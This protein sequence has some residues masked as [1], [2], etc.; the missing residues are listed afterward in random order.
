MKKQFTFL[1]LS[2]SLFFTS[3][4]SDDSGSTAGI[5]QSKI[6]GWWYRNANTSTISYNAYY[7]GEDGEYIQ[8]QSNLGM[9]QGVGTW[10]WTGADEVTITPAANGGIAGGV[11]VGKVLLLTNDSLVLHNQDLRLS[12]NNPA[13]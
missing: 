4:S 13:D 2:V 3:C 5:D 10:E 11:A 12:R 7:F 6:H 8:D 9:G 1:F